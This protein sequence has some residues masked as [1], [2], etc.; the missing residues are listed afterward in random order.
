MESQDRV[1][2]PSCYCLLQKD[3]Y[4]MELDGFR[5]LRLV[6][7]SGLIQDTEM[8][9]STWFEYTFDVDLR[10]MN[11]HVSV[12]WETSLRNLDLSR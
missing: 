2:V 11:P 7:V 1:Y 8:D 3:K 5:Y 9:T 12:W 6:D 4:H 10:L